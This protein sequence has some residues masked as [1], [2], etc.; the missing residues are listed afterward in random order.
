MTNLKKTLLVVL[1]P[2][3]VGKTELCIRLAQHF[4]TEIVSADSRQFYREMAIGT[5]KPTPEE[6]AEAPHH[7]IDSHSITQNYNVGDYEKDALACLDEIFSR[8]NFAIL[9]GGSGL[10]LQV[11]TDG[12]DDM[13]EVNP[14]IRERLMQQVETEGLEN[15]LTQLEQL[16]PDYYAKVDKAN[17]HR[18]VRALEVCLSTGK[19]FSSFRKQTKAERPF[20]IL[21]IGLER[22]REELYERINE[23]VDIM[24]AEGLLEEVKGLYDYKDHQA[25]QTVGYKEIFDHMDGQY[26][27]EE[28]IRL[29]KRNTRRYAKRQMTWFRRDEEIHWFSPKELEEI[30][31]WI[32]GK[33]H[34]ID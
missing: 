3:A 12:M 34:K 19:S 28:A 29:L 27:W 13:P 11:V 9:T 32:E 8:K 18:V 17:P 5:A 1:G 6:Q 20:D 15:L 26:D 22:D 25:L 14:E 21:K 31:M 7:F 24:L 30:V 33:V 23:R 2:T 10:Y 4:D 16:D